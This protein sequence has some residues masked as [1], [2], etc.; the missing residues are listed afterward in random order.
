MSNDVDS[1]EKGRDYPLTDS[2]QFDTFRFNALKML[3]K[4]ERQFKGFEKYIR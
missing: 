4:H 3:N 2:K 1:L